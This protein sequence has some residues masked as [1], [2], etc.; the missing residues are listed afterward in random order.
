M[1][2]HYRNTHGKRWE[3]LISFTSDFRKHHAQITS[4]CRYCGVVRVGGQGQTT[5]H[6]KQCTILFQCAVLCY[7]HGRRSAGQIEEFFGGENPDVSMAG[8]PINQKRQADR[9]SLPS[10]AT[11][12]PPAANSSQPKGKGKGQ[13]R[14]VQQSDQSTEELKQTIKLM[15]RAMVRHEDAIQTLRLDT[16]LV[17]FAQVGDGTPDTIS[18]IP[19][20]RGVAQKWHGKENPEMSS[21]PLREVMFMGILQRL[22]A[23]LDEVSKDQ[24]VALRCQHAGWLTTEQKWVY[25]KW[26]KETRTLIQDKTKIPV[27]HQTL[28]TSLKN[29]LRMVDEGPVLHRFCSTR[30]LDQYETGVAVFV[31]DLSIRGPNGT[32]VFQ[33]LLDFQGNTAWQLIGVQHRRENLQRAPVVQEILTRLDGM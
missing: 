7:D 12:L 16:G 3:E 13:R 24:A 9:S 5:A 2:N 33:G 22:L 10:K 11:K 27:L 17:W 25:Q 18:I 4:P 8:E 21:R 20:L 30:K 29:M 1:K 23:K 28:V 14:Q 32:Q 19:F 15:A 31:Q 26:C 6:A